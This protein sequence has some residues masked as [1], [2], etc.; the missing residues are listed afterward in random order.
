MIIHP[1]PGHV[2][3]GLL[4]VALTAFLIW[5]VIARRQINQRFLILLMLPGAFLWLFLWG[6][7][8]C[9][10]VVVHAD[11]STSRYMVIGRGNYTAPDGQKI[12][13][14]DDGNGDVFIVNASGQTMTDATVAYGK[15]NPFLPS[16]PDVIPPHRTLQCR[17]VP[18]YYPGEAPPETVSVRNGM[19]SDSRDWLRPAEENDLQYGDTSRVLP[20]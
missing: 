6:Q 2:L 18:D 14:R 19:K 16:A 11:I 1:I 15:Q 20:R 10:L 3:L 5:F 4:P 7:F 12:D 17:N 9:D 8:T 13:V